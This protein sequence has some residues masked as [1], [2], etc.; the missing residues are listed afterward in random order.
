[1]S[2]LLKTGSLPPLSPHVSFLGYPLPPPQRSRLLWMMPNWTNLKL[3][4]DIL[5]AR[6]RGSISKIDFALSPF[7]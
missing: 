5:Y 7:M 2:A 4:I 6:D 1:M 3:T